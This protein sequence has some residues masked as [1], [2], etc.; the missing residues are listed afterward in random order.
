MGVIHTMMNDDSDE[1]L[2]WVVLST[3]YGVR[4][5]HSYLENTKCVAVGEY[6]QVVEVPK[7]KLV[8]AHYG[9]SRS[10]GMDHLFGSIRFH[11]TRTSL[12]MSALNLRASGLAESEHLPPHMEDCV[13]R[14][15]KSTACLDF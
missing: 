7:A 4:G 15:G 10:I 11:P 12:Y 9:P 5:V 3:E 8:G 1:R 2:I 13:L 14:G 6:E